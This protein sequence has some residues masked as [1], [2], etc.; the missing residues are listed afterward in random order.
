MTWPVFFFFLYIYIYNLSVL[1]LLDP[2]EI[3]FSYLDVLVYFFRFVDIILN[4][5]LL[6]TW[7]EF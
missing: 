1:D 6:Y 5:L 2:K 4:Y 3:L 7:L